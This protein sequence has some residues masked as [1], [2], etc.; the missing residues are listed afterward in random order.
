M[1][2]HR[3]PK[4]AADIWKDIHKAEWSN[5]N[6]DRPKHDEMKIVVHERAKS[7]EHIQDLR[8]CAYTSFQH[9][10]G[11]VS[12]RSTSPHMPLTQYRSGATISGSE[13][14]RMNNR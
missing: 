9:G 4:V 1:K 6:N 12:E 14:I 7:V 11:F 13:R 3:M 2:T 5:L 8:M 10:H